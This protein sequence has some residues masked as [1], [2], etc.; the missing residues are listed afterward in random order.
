M[1]DVLDLCYDGY[2]YL[3]VWNGS[4]NAKK[5]RRLDKDEIKKQ[6]IKSMVNNDLVDTDQLKKKADKVEKPED[7]A[8]FI[9][10]YEDIIR[11]KKK[12]VISIAYY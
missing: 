7:A 9:K 11:T 3:Q 8:A 12:G 4:E 5:T 6:L 10:Q 1:K 2:F